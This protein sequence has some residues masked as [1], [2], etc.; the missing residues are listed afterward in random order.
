MCENEFGAGVSSDI[1]RF[2]KRNLEK[3]NQI[4][5]KRKERKNIFSGTCQDYSFY[6][7]ECSSKGGIR[8]GFERGKLFQRRL[9]SKSKN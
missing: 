1:K 6:S 7:Y 8:L 4:A 2:C 3:K 9:K 5:G